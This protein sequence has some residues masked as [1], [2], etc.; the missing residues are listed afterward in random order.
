MTAKSRPASGTTFRRLAEQRLREQKTEA[1]QLAAEPATQRLLHE[2]QVH[3]IELEMQNEEL[4]AARAEVEAGLER[5]VDLYDFAPVGYFTLAHDGTI[6]QVNLTGASMLGVGRAKLVNRRLGVF[7]ADPSRLA[8]N[9][10]LK[11]VFDGHAVST[12][13]AAIPREGREPL[14]VE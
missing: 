2:L 14:V 6:R 1:L 5:Y 12:C 4:L 11:G 7:L 9:A 13:E 10:F 8:F 3:Q